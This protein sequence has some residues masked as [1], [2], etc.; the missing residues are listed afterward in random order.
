[1]QKDF[2]AVIGL[3]WSLDLKRSGTELAIANQMDLGIG[4]QRKCCR[5]SQDLSIW[6]SVVP[7]PWRG[8][9][10]SQGG[11]KA[12]IHFKASDENVQLLLKIVM[13]ISQFSLYGTVADMIKELPVGQRAP[14]KPVASGQLDKQEI[15]TQLPLAELQ[16]NEE[17][18]GNLL[19]EYEQRFEKF[20]RRPEVIQTLLRIISRNWTI[21][22]CSSITKRK[23]KSLFMPRKN[24][25]SRSKRN[26]NKKD[27]SKAMYDLPQFR[28]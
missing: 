20:I 4:L 2:L 11:G 13:S 12:T 6:Y 8:Q 28:T 24:H 10:R 14:G 19:Q 21:F 5:I 25:A 27:G 1:M 22:L 17:R 26:S 16:A 3:S 23:S 18:Q 9:L 15:L 7:V